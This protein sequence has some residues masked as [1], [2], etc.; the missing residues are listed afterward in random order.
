MAREPSVCGLIS[1]DH[2]A[3]TP[4]LPEVR[5]TLLRYL[6]DEWGNPSSY[7]RRGTP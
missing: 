2:N 4:G 7:H 6:G 3:A 1:L 5:Q